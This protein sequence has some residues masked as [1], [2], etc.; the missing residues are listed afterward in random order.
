MSNTMK[1]LP[2]TFHKLMAVQHGKDYHTIARRVEVPMAL[3]GPGKVLVR[4]RYA[5]VNASDINI[6]SGAYGTLFQLPQDLGTEAMGE[7]AALG[8]GVAGMAPGDAVAFLRAGAYG[9]YVVL[10]ARRLIRL[11]SLAPPGS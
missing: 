11:P 9:E 2:D 3:P 6:T 5:G 1:K 10:D 4:I 7:V 8:E